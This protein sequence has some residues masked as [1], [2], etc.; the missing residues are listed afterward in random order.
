MS[1][2]FQKQKHGLILETR[3]EK[4]QDYQFMETL[5]L[6]KRVNLQNEILKSID[7]AILNS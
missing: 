3:L 5:P 1:D 2:V 7:E 4:E 6:N